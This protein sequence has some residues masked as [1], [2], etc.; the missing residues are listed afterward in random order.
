[1]RVCEIFRSIQ[2][3]GTMQGSPCTF[4]RLA[5]CN[6]KC[7]WCDTPY[8]QEGGTE[9]TAEEVLEGINS[10][11]GHRICITGGEPLLQ[12][13]E[14][15]P[16]VK[17]LAMEGREIEIQTNGTQGFSS[18]QRFA[19][20]CMD[21]KCPSSGERSDLGLLRTITAKD[22]VKFV[23]LD[24]NDMEYAEGVIGTHRIEGEIFISPVHGTD[25][26]G[27]VARI[28]RNDLPVRFQ[29]QLHKLIG[30]R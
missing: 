25:F 3:E 4:L 9:L 17:D 27:I 15:V 16:L 5:G 28:I 23:V 14:L 13:D 1:M 20:I 7:R 11:G 29:L 8:A 6:L 2:G 24:S 18:V 19:R 26:S 10:L 22:S 30:V 12:S 21:V